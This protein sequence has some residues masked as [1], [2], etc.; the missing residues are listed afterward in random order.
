MPNHTISRS[1][2]NRVR[3]ALET[4]RPINDLALISW[5][6]RCTTKAF[7]GQKYTPFDYALKLLYR[8]RDVGRIR[9][10]T[11]K[12]PPMSEETARAFFRLAEPTDVHRDIKP[13]NV[14]GGT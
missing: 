4:D 3:R 6:S 14:I 8:P 1:D 11:F 13:G 12:T 5:A 10:R 7:P 2:R 9:Y